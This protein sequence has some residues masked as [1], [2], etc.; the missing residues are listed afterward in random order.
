M[1]E[2][3]MVQIPK[4]IGVKASK[5][6]GNE[7]AAY[8]QEVVGEYAVDGWEFYRVD[9]INVSVLPGCLSGLF[10]GREQVDAYNVISF[11]RQR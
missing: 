1:Y 9:T 3:T 11:R 4:N 6:K 8:L 10:G 7:A 5:H 2:Y